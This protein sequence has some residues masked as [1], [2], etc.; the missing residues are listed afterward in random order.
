VNYAGDEAVVEKGL[1]LIA[2]LVTRLYETGK[3]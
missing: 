3:P 2:D 1:S